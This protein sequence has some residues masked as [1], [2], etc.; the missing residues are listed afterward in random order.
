MS[1]DGHLIA[2]GLGSPNLVQLR[3]L[4]GG[5]LVGELRGQADWAAA[6]DLCF[7]ADGKYLVDGRE[8]GQLVVWDLATRKPVFV[9]AA[10]PIAIFAVAF[11][12]DGRLVAC[13]GKG[14]RIQF[15]DASTGKLLRTLKGHEG[16]V[17]DLAFAPNGRQLASGGWDEVVRLWDVDSGN[18][19]LAIPGQSG[20]IMHLGFLPGGDRVVVSTGRTITI[21]NTATGRPVTRVPG[22]RQLGAGFDISRDGAYFLTCSNDGTVR[23]WE[24]AEVVPRVLHM[25]DWVNHVAFSDDGS[26]VAAGDSTSLISL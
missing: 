5:R 16:A 10:D 23:L 25:R 17:F 20:F 1:A 2:V 26:M 22:H 12:P 7:S 4:P 8:H 19:R 24:L 14:G 21:W 3:S 11:H 15:W 6:S 9:A 13:A 18:L